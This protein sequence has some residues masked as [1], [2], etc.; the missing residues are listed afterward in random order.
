MKNRTILPC[1]ITVTNDE[2][3]IFMEMAVNNFKK[4][5]QV[6]IDCMGDDYE[7]HFKDRRY[8]EDVIAKVIERTKQDFAETMRDNKG[9]EYY[10]FL[11]EVRRNL[12]VIYSAYRTNY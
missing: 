11:D 5:L 3:E 8:I 2:T 1:V 9:K 12:R 6:M 4:H 10:L 7:R